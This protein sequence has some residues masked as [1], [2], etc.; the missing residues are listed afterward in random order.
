[1]FS[2]DYHFDNVTS[3][4]SFVRAFCS[5]VSNRV[6]LIPG[7]TLEKASANLFPH[8][9]QSGSSFWWVGPGEV[10]CNQMHRC[11]RQRNMSSERG[12]KLGAAERVG[13]YVWIDHTMTLGEARV[14]S[15]EMVAVPRA[16]AT[17]THSSLVLNWLRLPH[18]RVWIIMMLTPVCI[19]C[20]VATCVVL[21]LPQDT[22]RC[23]F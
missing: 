19:F 9:P 1:M 18:T 6:H 15:H 17:I 4:W 23:W 10:L 13:L 11:I 8:L 20:R 14:T 5:V 3:H 21:V 22:M 7:L 16:C 12:G 2:T